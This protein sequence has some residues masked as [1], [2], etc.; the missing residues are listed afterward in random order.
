MPGFYT[1]KSCGKAHVWCGIC[2]PEATIKISRKLKGRVSPTKGIKDSVERKKKKSDA[3][4]LAYFE[5][6]RKANFGSQFSKPTKYNKIWFRS[7]M[8]VSFAK[9][10]NSKKITWIYEPKRFILSDG[11]SYLP[12]FYLPN[13][14]I[15]VEVKGRI[16]EDGIKRMNQFSEQYNQKVILADSDYFK[17]KGIPRI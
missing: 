1:I 14:N 12:D 10:L 15:Y 7:K 5:G 3:A 2:N 6:R 11:S 8:E 16:F 17:R 13:R 9:W 4:K